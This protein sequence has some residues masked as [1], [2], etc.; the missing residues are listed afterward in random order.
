MRNSPSG[1]PP[2]NRV[3]LIRASELAQYGFCQRAWW[4]ET[5]EKR[6]S[7]RRTDRARGSRQHER[8]ARRVWLASRWRWLSW[9]LLAGGL[10]LMTVFLWLWLF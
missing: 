1:P 2:P 7:T 9:G 3:P 6:T 10:L 4:L 8:H 5:V